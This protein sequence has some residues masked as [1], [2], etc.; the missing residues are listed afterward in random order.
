MKRAHST[1]CDKELHT[2]YSLQ[3]H[4]ENSYISQ[5]RDIGMGGLRNAAQERYSLQSKSEGP[6]DIH[7]GI[8]C[9]FV[10]N[11]GLPLGAKP[12][13]TLGTGGGWGLSHLAH[14][15]DPCRDSG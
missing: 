1:K 13:A 4:L 10:C 14:R 15:D 6:G 12:A 3:M 11:S 7:L 5:N 9:R 2:D 8:W